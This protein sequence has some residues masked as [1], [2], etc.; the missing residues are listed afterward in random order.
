MN[1]ASSFELSNGFF[2]FAFLIFR[3][4]DRLKISCLFLQRDIDSNLFLDGL[5]EGDNPV[6]TH[7]PPP[8]CG[9]GKG[10]GE[11]GREGGYPGKA[12]FVASFK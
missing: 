12:G 1:Q 7:S 6:M 3:L 2:S 11:G 5:V 10:E 9:R 4:F 8:H